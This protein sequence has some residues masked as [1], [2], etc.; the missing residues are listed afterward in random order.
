MP[1]CL[2]GE[3]LEFFREVLV[4]A[5]P[6]HTVQLWSLE[7]EGDSWDGASIPRLWWSIIGH[8]LTVNF[9]W[10]SFWHDRMCEVANTWSE[11]RLADAVLLLLLDQAG[12][13]YWRRTAMWAAVRLYAWLWWSWRD[14][15]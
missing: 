4:F 3:R 11:R 15:R 9:R 5:N 10:A 2:R 1:V 7:G 8:P 14:W 13:A 12:V 6:C